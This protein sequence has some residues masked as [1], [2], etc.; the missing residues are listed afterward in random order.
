[1]C[2]IFILQ[3]TMPNYGLPQHRT[4]IIEII[5][6]N[7]ML[8]QCGLAIYFYVK[9]YCFFLYKTRKRNILSKLLLFELGMIFVFTIY[10]QFMRNYTKS[11]QEFC[12]HISRQ[13]SIDSWQ[14]PIFKFQLFFCVMDIYTKISCDRQIFV[15]KSGILNI[16]FHYEPSVI[17]SCQTFV[18]FWRLKRCITDLQQCSTIILCT[19]CCQLLLNFIEELVGCMQCRV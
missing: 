15:A 1:M 16:F 13:Q 11:V 4:K 12:L 2:I 17:V 14:A 5:T 7:C 10:G 18:I 3:G 19:F 9:I 8:Q 6:L